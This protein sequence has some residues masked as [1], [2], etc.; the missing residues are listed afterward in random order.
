ERSL[1]VLDGAIAVFDGSNGVEPQSETVW[2]Q[3]DR[4]GVPR[5]CF[6]NKMDKVGADFVMC[7]ESIVERLAA[8]P[9]AVHWPVGA[10]DTFEG[11]VDLVT[12]R[13]ARN[14]D[15]TSLGAQFEWTDVPEDMLDLCQEKR[16]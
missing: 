15:E 10:E 16:L 2:R 8:K 12:M 7:L 9:V 3:A 14:F 5:I 4:Y 11:V 1:R 6:I 13:A